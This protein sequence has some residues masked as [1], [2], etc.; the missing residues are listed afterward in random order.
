MIISYLYAELIILLLLEFFSKYHQWVLLAF[1]SFSIIYGCRQCVPTV[2]P[3]SETAP[4]PV[5][6]QIRNYQRMEQNLTSTASSGTNLHGSP[7]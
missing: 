5:P 1:L 4:I 6:T 7:R 3:P 2:S